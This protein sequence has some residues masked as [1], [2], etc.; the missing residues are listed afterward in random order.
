MSH[1][2][3]RIREVWS[4]SWAHSHCRIFS[5]QKSSLPL[6]RLVSTMLQRRSKKKWYEQT[7]NWKSVSNDGSHFYWHGDLFLLNDVRLLDQSML[8]DDGELRRF[9]PE[10]RHDV[11]DE[12]PDLAH[13]EVRTDAEL[14]F[15]RGRGT[16][17]S[18]PNF[19]ADS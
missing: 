16:I 19:S 14:K 9:K 4:Y 11:D 2:F 6:S 10:T 18:S 3:P 17:V 12:R 8:W 13:C 7:E 15:E 5:E 1:L